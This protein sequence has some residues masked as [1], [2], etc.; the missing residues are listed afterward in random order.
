MESVPI[1]S[2]VWPEAIVQ[3]TGEAIVGSGEQ[4][5]VAKQFKRFWAAAWVFGPS[6][7]YKKR[8]KSEI[9][10]WNTGCMAFFIYK[11]MQRYGNFIGTICTT[12]LK[13]LEC[14]FYW[15]R[16]SALNCLKGWG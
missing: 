2:P 3:V 8:A 6:G 1:V 13:V 7:I 11:C 15:W 4:Q 9:K 10:Y 16:M 14:C 12:N 5:E